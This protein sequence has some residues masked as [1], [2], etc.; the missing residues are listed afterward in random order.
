M[1]G[2]YINHNQ[3][4][5]YMRYRKTANLSQAAAAAKTGISERSG[6][7]IEKEQHHTN[8]PKAPR[9]Y[10]TRSSPLDKVW[11]NELEPMLQQSPEL[12]AKT[13][14]IHLQRTHLDDKNL[15]VYTHS[16]LRTL[17]RYVSKWKALNGKAKAIMFP[18]NHIPGEQGLSDFTELNDSVV[19]INGKP[20]K[21]KL[22]HFRLVYSKWS[23]LKVIQSGE[24]IQA[25]SEGLQEALYA[26]GGAPREHRT[27]SLSAAFKNLSKEALDDLTEQYKDL[28]AHYNM[29]PSRNNKGEKHENGSVE[30]SHGHIKNRIKQ[31]LILR[32]SNDFA[33]IE[34]Y[35]TWLHS[36]VKSS[37]QRNS[38]DFEA[39][40]LALQPLPKHKAADYEVKS[41]HVS[42]LSLVRIKGLQYSI[43]SRLSGHTITLHIYQKEIKLYLGSTFVYSCLRRYQNPKSQPYVIDYKH[44][45]PA[46]IK[47]PAAFRNC[48]YRDELFPNAE[49]HK[50]WQ[51]FEQT[52]SKK[53]APKLMLRLLKLAADYD[54][55]TELSHHVM[56][57]IKSK[58]AIEIEVIES[59]F[60]LSNPVLPNIECKQHELAQYDLIINQPKGAVHATL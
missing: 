11:A 22:Y 34:S 18:Q 17:Q 28:C 4:K 51:H 41:V 58:Q 35:E 37:N 16:V 26:L 40:K 19:T 47:K 57:L 2:K 6:R 27:D 54:C 30:S 3:A 39:E 12:Q 31:E 55:E 45:V 52:E 23:Y 20:F 53:T 36:I 5:L 24:S 38:C 29:M 7:K 48:K 9:A 42:N 46:L 32:G 14:F 50:I 25:L 56:Q 44:V 21:H 43:P 59:Q 15:P 33:S 13:L 60:N 49:Y 8:K 10:K 1:G